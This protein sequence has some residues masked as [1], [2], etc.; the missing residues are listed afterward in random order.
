LRIARSARKSNAGPAA[1][2]RGE[3]EEE[4]EEEWNSPEERGRVPKRPTS[5]KKG[6]EARG[7]A[8]NNVLSRS[9]EAPYFGYSAVQECV[10]RNG[11]YGQ[12]VR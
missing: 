1:K 10:F 9:R 11:S 12:T 5:S 3:E 7:E 8:L 6:T 4:E 2:R